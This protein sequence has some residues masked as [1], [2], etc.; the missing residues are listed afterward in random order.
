MGL[1]IS[2][3]RVM[4]VWKQFILHFPGT[5]RKWDTSRRPCEEHCQLNMPADKSFSRNYL[6][7]CS[8][9]G[10]AALAAAL[11]EQKIFIFTRTDLTSPPRSMQLYFLVQLR[12]SRNLPISFPRSG[13]MSRIL[14]IGKQGKINPVHSYFPQCV[15]HCR[16]NPDN[17]ID[18]VGVSP[19]VDR[20][21]LKMHDFLPFQLSSF[22][23]RVRVVRSIDLKYWRY[24]S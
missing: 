14:L 16:A 9:V 2:F 6:Q 10:G 19:T 7:S 11:V 5:M 3:P 18:I 21:R 8:S 24:R 1:G 13:I 12:R 4:L 23:I 22:C 17:V 20:K 15:P